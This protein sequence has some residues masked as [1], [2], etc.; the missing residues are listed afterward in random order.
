[1]LVLSW[2]LFSLLLF[3]HVARFILIIIKIKR[4]P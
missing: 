4:K 3:L 2:L 1:L